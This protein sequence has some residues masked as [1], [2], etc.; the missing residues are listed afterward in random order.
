[1]T[2]IVNPAIE[3]SNDIKVI[4]RK[5]EVPAGL[6]SIKSIKH[7]TNTI[8]D[9]PFSKMVADP[10]R[11]ALMISINNTITQKSIN[12]L[13]DVNAHSAPDGK[14]I[15]NSSPPALKSTPAKVI[16]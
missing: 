15:L 4:I 13:L 3:S 14:P 12:K 16:I 6:K 11:V 7:R 8:I 1:M 10:D 5:V 9:S 2:V